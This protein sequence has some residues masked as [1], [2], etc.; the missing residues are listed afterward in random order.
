MSR[1]TPAVVIE[2]AYQIGLFGNHV[3]HRSLTDPVD[4]ALTRFVSRC[5]Y[6]AIR[7]RECA[8][9]AAAQAKRKGQPWLLRLI[10]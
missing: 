6:S 2:I 5:S 7:N 8:E 9:P 4:I 1:V 10:R 3:A